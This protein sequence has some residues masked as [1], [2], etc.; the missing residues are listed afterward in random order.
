MTTC[1]RTLAIDAD[2][3][4]LGSGQIAALTS[5]NIAGLST[6]APGSLLAVLGTLMLATVLSVL[7]PK[8]E[9]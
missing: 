4:A 5:T 3:Y 2:A 6:L 8:K 1:G 7:W 9:S